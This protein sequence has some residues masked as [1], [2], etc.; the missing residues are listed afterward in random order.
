MMITHYH[1]FSEHFPLQPYGLEF[2]VTEAFVFLCDNAS[3]MVVSWSRDDDDG[4]AKNSHHLFMA[5]H[6]PYTL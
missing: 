1:V 6:K 2:N 4:D 5:C 3:P